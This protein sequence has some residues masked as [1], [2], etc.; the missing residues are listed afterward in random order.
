MFKIHSVL[1]NIYKLTSLNNGTITTVHHLKSAN[2]E[3]YNFSHKVQTLNWLSV[4]SMISYSNKIFTL[5]INI[6]H[7][8]LSVQRNHHI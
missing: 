2:G 6:H 8:S 4:H 3:K 7:F 5:Q 1:I